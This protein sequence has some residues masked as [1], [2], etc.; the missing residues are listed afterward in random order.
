MPLFSVRLLFAKRVFHPH[1]PIE[2]GS[3]RT[4]INQVSDQV[5]WMLQWTL[6]VGL[7]RH[8]VATVR[9]SNLI[10]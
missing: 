8:R 5:P 7:G 1:H 2:H 3:T 10:P 4:V 9:D 6:A